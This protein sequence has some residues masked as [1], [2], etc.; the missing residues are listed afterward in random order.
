MEFRYSPPPCG[1]AGLKAEWESGFRIAA[2][3]ENGVVSIRANQEGLITLAKHLLTLAQPDVPSGHHFHYDS[4]TCLDD[5]SV[6]F[7]L[8]RTDSWAED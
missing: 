4:F 5:D 3:F 7:I 6:S 2:L 1:P 8:E